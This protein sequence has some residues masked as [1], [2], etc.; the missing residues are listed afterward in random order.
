MPDHYHVII[1]GGGSAGTVAATRLSEDPARKVLLLEAGPDPQPL[2]ELVAQADLQARLLLESPFVMMYPTA[3]NLDGSTFYTL[4][5]RIMGGG[6]SVNVM[7]APRP[8]K[9]DMD[10]WTS[11]G[12]EGWTY[13][14]VLPILKRIESD[15]DYPDSP[16]HGSSG[17]LYVR[18][19]WKLHEPASEP[20]E[21]Y[22]ERAVDMGLPICPDMNVAEPFGVC[23]SPYNIK[24]GQRQSTTVAY[25][26]MARGRANLS[27]VPEANVTGLN[28]DGRRVTGVTYEKDGQ[29]QTATADRIVMCAGAIHTPHLLMLSGIGP[30]EELIKQG[31]KVLH[32]LPGIGQNHQ[33]HPTVYMTFEGPAAFKEDWIIPRFRLLYKSP[34][35][36][37]PFDFHVHM[38]PATE[39]AG[40][41]RM[42]P[43]SMSLLEQRNRGR[44][45]LRSADP[46]DDPLVE[47]N[48][49][50]D[51]GDVEAML[52]AMHFIY[53]L[54]QHPSMKDYYGPLLQ[55]GQKEDWANFARTTF[56]S[57]HHS[58]GTCLM[59]PASN[60][61]AVVDQRL[62]VHGLDNLYVADASIMPTVSH[63]NTNVT[64][65]M[66]GERVADFLKEG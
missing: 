34:N 60:P 14:D 51:P 55:P 26:S 9:W 10:S 59:A 65:L 37:A 19:P 18:R 42:M 24:D 52:A 39:V 23:A 1:V 54:A 22:I 38:R 28:L 21:A 44:V 32:E 2:P 25:L 33:D 16:I 17:P 3:R 43:I 4:T 62:K 66:I 50:D 12:N 40:L 8:T 20:V 11:F 35:S 29:T 41:K 61:M 47:A 63:A 27:I 7:A 46:H 49:L 48:M 53:D 57:Y 56:D 31:I 58:V 15:Q 6:S 30:S 13:D 45:G 5:G 64:C 36:R